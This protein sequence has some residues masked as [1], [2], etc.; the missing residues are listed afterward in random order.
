MLVT[1]GGS[2]IGAGVADY[3][4]ERG[5]R[6]TICGRRRERVDAVAARLGE[7]CRSVQADVTRDA[8]RRLLVDAAMDHGGGLD[9]LVNNAANMYRGTVEELDEQGLLGNRDPC[10]PR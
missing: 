6:V 10:I 2:G 4:C 3:F 7:N 8:E 5:A 9:A 1:G